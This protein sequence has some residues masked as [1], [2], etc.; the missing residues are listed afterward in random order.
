M[1]DQ[2]IL[3]QAMLETAEEAFI[4]ADSSGLIIMV[5]HEVHTLW[6]YTS[7]ELIGQPLTRLMPEKYKDQQLL[8]IKHYLKTHALHGLSN[9]IE[10]EGR[11]KDGSIFPLEMRIKEISVEG[12]QLFSAEMRDLTKTKQAQQLLQMQYAVV[13]ILAESRRLDDAALNILKVICETLTWDLGLLWTIDAE[14]QVLRCL[15]TWDCSS[16][17]LDEFITL[18]QSRTFMPGI[19]LPGRVWQ[20]GQPVWI[21]KLVE[22]KNFPR[23]ALASGVG[24][25]TGF[26]F[27]IV[28][29]NEVLGVIEFFNRQVVEPDPALLSMLTALGSQIGQFIERKRAEEQLLG[30]QKMLSDFIENAAMGLHWV[31]PDGVILWANKAE[32]DMMGYTAEEYIGHNIVEFH[33]DERIHDI[34][35]RLACNETLND[36]EAALRCKD[37]TIK[38]VLINSNVLFENGKFIHTRCFTRDITLAKQ[39]ELERQQLFEQAQEAIRVRDE[40]LS[41]A[42]HEL[43]TPITSLRGFAQLLLRQ[44]DQGKLLDPERIQRALFTINE[45]SIRLNELVTQLLDVSRVEGGR[46]ILDRKVVDLVPLLRALIN[47]MQLTT[48][49]QE[50]ILKAPDTLQAKIDPLRIEQVVTNL[51]DNAIK[52]SPMGSPVVVEIAASGPGT[53]QLTVTDHG[54]GIPTEAQ[55]YIF[56]RFFQANS[57]DQVGGM[58]L[59]LYISRQIVELHGG[60]IGFQPIDQG[61]TCFTVTVPINS[62][63]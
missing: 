54:V 32:L 46:L 44:L 53:F 12:Q 36:Y 51:L 50:L 61:G 37:G 25:C 31:G 9:R 17:P 33:A 47:R 2:N 3:L 43:R 7:E 18:N 41:V 63:N 15:K 34:L 57:K 6:G 20:D 56:D 4:A 19:G 39:A 22:D 8:G 35:N 11:K 52:F 21:S 38:Y 48:G 29:G 10:L 59:G 23:S 26:G 5:N 1:T 45:Q 58:G 30:S 60:S 24:L 16:L 49:R 13:R 55:P 27:P 42:A 62:N 40:F 14:D 28:N